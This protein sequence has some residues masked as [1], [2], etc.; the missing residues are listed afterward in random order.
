[1]RTR[2]IRWAKGMFNLVCTL[3]ALCLPLGVLGASTPPAR[4]KPVD[5]LGPM[6]GPSISLMV[7]VLA[8]GSVALTVKVILHQGRNRARTL[9][10]RSHRWRSASA[11]TQPATPAPRQSHPSEPRIIDMNV[12]LPE[13]APPRSPPSTPTEDR[14]FRPTTTRFD[15][16]PSVPTENPPFD[17]A[18][19]IEELDWYQFEKLV[20]LLFSNE[21]WQVERRGGANEDGGIDLIARRPGRDDLAVQCK[22][23]KAWNLG[24][25]RV[26]EFLGALMHAELKAGLIIATKGYTDQAERL[27]RQ[28]NIRLMDKSALIRRLEETGSRFAPAVRALLEDPTKHCPKCEAPMILRQTA[29]PFWGCSR[30]PRCRGKMPA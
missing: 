17:W 9:H 1:M 8:G 28:H 24:V 14:S 10:T 22:H 27:A 5:I 2:R 19:T 21:G 20:A 29:T 12:V 26:R 7:L 3:A 23:W 16:E 4:P 13:E 18:Q 25:A 6:L 30:Y 15:R 11:S